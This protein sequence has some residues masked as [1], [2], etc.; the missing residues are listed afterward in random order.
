MLTDLIVARLLHTVTLTSLM[1][2]GKPE[3]ARVTKYPPLLPPVEGF[4][5]VVVRGTEIGEAPEARAAIP[6]LLT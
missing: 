5:E 1:L 4:T 2:E 3:P 6:T